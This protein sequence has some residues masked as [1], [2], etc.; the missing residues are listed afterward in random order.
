MWKVGPPVAALFLIILG[1]QF[2]PR[3]HAIEARRLSKAAVRTCARQVI[4]DWV[5]DGRIRDG[6]RRECYQ[7]AL[8]MGTR[9]G[10]NPETLYGASVFADLHERLRTS[11]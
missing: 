10:M 8:D 5:R 6:Y 4:N 9:G 3:A 2:W 7:A 11:G 1:T